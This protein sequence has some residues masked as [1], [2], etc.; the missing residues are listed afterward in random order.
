MKWEKKGLI[1]CSEGKLWWTKTHAM[2]PTPDLL[3]EKVIRVYAGF[4]DEKKVG[5]IGF[6]DVD[7]DNPSLVLN[8]SDKPVLDTGIPGTF[9]DN[10]VHPSSIV[11]LGDEK[12]LYYLGFQIGVKVRYYVT[13]GLAISRDR[14]KTFKRYSQVPILERSDAD[15]FFRTAPCVILD[16]GIWKMWYVG[17]SQWT[18]VN[19]KLVPVYRIK[20]L[21]SKD[22]INWGDEGKVCIDF[23][24]EDEHGF[25]RPFVVKGDSMYKMFY[26]IR[27]RS[28]GYRLGYAESK[29]GVNWIRRDEEV[30]IDVSDS[31]WDS[32]MVCFSSI[33]KVGGKTYMFYNGNNFGETGFGYAVL[34]E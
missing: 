20:Y 16:D 32:K 12:Y 8:I 13:S 24:N 34:S 27:T 28:K 4:C 3:D 11:N 1:Y 7:A 18:E 33:L 9:D 19:G 30:G 21:E 26:S 17:G 31:G 23:L 15:L 22:G 5:R 25:G 10:G 14:G 2:I 29:D 6:V